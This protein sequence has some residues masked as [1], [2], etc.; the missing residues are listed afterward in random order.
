MWVDTAGLP[1]AEPSRRCGVYRGMLV[2]S[3]K[4]LLFPSPVLNLILDFLSSATFWKT[5]ADIG[6]PTQEVNRKG[7]VH[8]IFTGFEARNIALKYLVLVD[9]LAL[10]MLHDQIVS[11]TLVNASRTLGP[12]PP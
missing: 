7:I 2:F 4:V 3:R 5:T 1:T 11:G 9:G 6:D 10:V 12:G 8:G